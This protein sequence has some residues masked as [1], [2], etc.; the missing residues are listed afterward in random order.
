MMN[1][2]ITHLVK[3]LGD[4]RMGTALLQLMDYYN[5]NNLASISQEQAEIF[6]MLYDNIME[7]NPNLGY[8]G[9]PRKK[10]NKK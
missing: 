6:Y 4:W 5:V 10:G 8:Y 7:A 2:K 1:D 3:S 9:Y